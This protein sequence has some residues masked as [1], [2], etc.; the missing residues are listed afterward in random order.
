MRDIDLLEF[1]PEKA[2]CGKLRGEVPI[3]VKTD[4]LYLS[5]SYYNKK[6]YKNLTKIDFSGI[7]VAFYTISLVSRYIYSNELRDKK[8]SGVIK[9]R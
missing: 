5:F 1:I 9:L 7:S 3:N 6:E 4:N 2:T 8:N